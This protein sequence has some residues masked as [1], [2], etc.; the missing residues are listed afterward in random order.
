MME[1]TYMAEGNKLLYVIVTSSSP[2]IVLTADEEVPPGTYLDTTGANATVL[3]QTNSLIN[4]KGFSLSYY[5]CTF[6][7]F[8]SD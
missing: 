2:Y 1:L 8:I 7:C 4:R 6:T 5:G 3:F